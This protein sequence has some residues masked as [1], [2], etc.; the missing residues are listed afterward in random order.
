[1]RATEHSRLMASW[2]GQHFHSTF[3]AKARGVSI[4]VG[5]H[6]HFESDNIIADKNGRY[7]IVSGK[8]FITKVIFA[9][10]YAPN[11][12]DVSFFNRFFSLLDGLDT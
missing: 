10:V 1:M 6:V 7:I 4:L 8:L 12:D 3:Q 2:A 5:K 11:A 9:N